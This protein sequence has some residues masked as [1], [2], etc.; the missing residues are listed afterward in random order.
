MSRNVVFDLGR[1]TRHE[2]DHREDY[3][4]SSCELTEKSMHEWDKEEPEEKMR[5]VRAAPRSRTAPLFAPLG[6]SGAWA[7]AQHSARSR[8]LGCVRAALRVEQARE[9]V[10]LG[11]GGLSMFIAEHARRVGAACSSV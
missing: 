8:L 5:Q 7:R 9:I 11:G 2:A 10:G 1:N 4:R 6:A 3:D